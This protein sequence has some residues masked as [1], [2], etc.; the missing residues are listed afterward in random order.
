MRRRLVIRYGLNLLAAASALI[1]TA[2]VYLWVR[3]HNEDEWLQWTRSA[4]LDPHTS[5]LRICTLA[6]GQGRMGAYLK[7]EV[8]WNPH[9]PAQPHP[10]YAPGTPLKIERRRG[11]FYHGGRDGTLLDWLGFRIAS[12]GTV[13]G[14]D[15]NGNVVSAVVA[16]STVSVSSRYA[17]V[18]CWFVVGAAALLPL[19][20][21]KW[22]WTRLRRHR[23]GLCMHCGYDVRGSSEKCPEC[24]RPIDFPLPKSDVNGTR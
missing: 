13:I 19:L 5:R 21:A 1:C 2:S 20:R 12:K 6:V 9:R 23:R 18:P 22:Y 15:H 8:R 7:D 24:G 11:G 10:D 3:T 16:E 4:L 14:R 17:G